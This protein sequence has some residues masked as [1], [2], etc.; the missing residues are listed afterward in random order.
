VE[1]SIQPEL[2]IAR[3]AQERMLADIT[4]ADAE[5]FCSLLHILFH[6]GVWT[7]GNEQQ[8]KATREQAVQHPNS[9]ILWA[10]S[11]WARDFLTYE[12]VVLTLS[13]AAIRRSPPPV[14][15]EHIYKI[16]NIA[17]TVLFQGNALYGE[18]LNSKSITESS[19]FNH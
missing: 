5:Y 1:L 15:P 6:D 10:L 8:W 14:W 18:F 7:S 16:L 17:G 3:Q 13:H 19:Y 9:V 11:G 2:S 4:M 12:N